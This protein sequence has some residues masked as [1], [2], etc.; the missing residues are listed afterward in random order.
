MK[1]ALHTLRFA[2]E[3]CMLAAVAYWAV[4]LHTGL[5]VRIAL[6]VVVTLAVCVVWGVFV[7]PKARRPLPRPA[8]VGL[9][10]VLFGLAAAALAQAGQSGL[11]IA[12]FVASV[13]DLAALVAIAEDGL[14]GIGAP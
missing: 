4:S 5:A 1:L 9:Q 8:W 12:F 13:A 14:S 10:L 11:G 2:L 3:L 6:A 7:A